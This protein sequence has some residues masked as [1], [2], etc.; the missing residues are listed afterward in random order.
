MAY[1]GGVFKRPGV[2]GMALEEVLRR[3]AP[4]CVVTE[5]RFS[6]PV[7]A[8]LLALKWLGVEVGEGLLLEVERSVEELEVDWSYGAG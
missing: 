6:A 5:P 4:D 7:G 2:Y 8:A 3:E 1:C